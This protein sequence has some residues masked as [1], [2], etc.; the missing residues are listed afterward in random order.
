[1]FS[2]INRFISYDLK[3]ERNC[4]RIT[5]R[6]LKRVIKSTINE[7]SHE[8][9]LIHRADSSLNYKND[10]MQK[11]ESCMRM[12]VKE[13]LMM[14]TLIC[15]QNVDMCEHCKMLFMCICDNNIQGCCECLNNICSCQKCYDI[16]KICC[17][18]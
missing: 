11:A 14:C 3:K 7:M 18:C 17:G 9:S 13:L 5:E 8:N 4:M 2:R 10:V 6:Q 15:S 16:C 1:M 12:D